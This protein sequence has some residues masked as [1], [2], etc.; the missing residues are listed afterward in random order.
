MHSRTACPWMEH[1]AAAN[2]AD[3]AR[4]AGSEA[5]FMRRQVVVTGRNTPDL[6]DGRIG[7][8]GRERAVADTIERARTVV[9]RA[10]KRLSHMNGCSCYG[11]GGIG[12]VRN[13]DW[14]VAAGSRLRTRRDSSV[15]TGSLS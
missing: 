12:D 7:L 14:N 6:I 9:S 11:D 13:S 5:S 2:I 4:T 15:T 8:A 1:G 10:G 3:G